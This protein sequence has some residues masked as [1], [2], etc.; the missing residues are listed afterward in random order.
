MALSNNSINSVAKLIAKK[1]GVS[2]FEFWLDIAELVGEVELPINEHCRE[3][4]DITADMDDNFNALK[5]CLIDLYKSCHCKNINS[6]ICPITAL[7][8]LG[9]R[10]YNLKRRK[11]GVDI[12]DIDI[13][14]HI[15]LYVVEQYL[16]TVIEP[17]H[18]QR[19]ILVRLDWYKTRK[20]NHCCPVN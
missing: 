14:E 15:G 2:F 13:I 6:P 9:Q 10:C 3:L 7:D 16:T 8:I 18:Q 12:K 5:Q 11:S 17:T 19:G 1:Q 20:Q 4:K